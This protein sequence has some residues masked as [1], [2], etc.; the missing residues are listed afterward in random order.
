MNNT[1]GNHPDSSSEYHSVNLD[2]F[3][4]SSWIR[5][6]ASKALSTAISLISITFSSLSVTFTPPVNPWDQVSVNINSGQEAANP[7]I[8]GML[9]AIPATACNV[10]IGVAHVPTYQ[11]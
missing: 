2:W 1:H 7:R 5:R 11:D 4:W 3:F 6:I 9:A 10:G 8:Q